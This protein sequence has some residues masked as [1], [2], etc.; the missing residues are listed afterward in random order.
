MELDVL[1]RISEKPV[2]KMTKSDCR[3]A[4]GI[5]MKLADLFSQVCN[6]TG[7]DPESV[8]RYYIEKDEM[9][10]GT[11]LAD[12][13]VCQPLN[14]SAAGFANDAL[15]MA[16]RLSEYL[17][18]KAFLGDAATILSEAGR[19]DEAGAQA[20]KNMQEFP[21]EAWIYIT[22]AEAYKRAGAPDKSSEIFHRA[23]DVV[24]DKTFRSDVYERF[25]EFLKRTGNTAEAGKLEEQFRRENSDDKY[26][27]KPVGKIVFSPHSE[28]KGTSGKG[29]E[30]IGR[31]DPCPC[32]SG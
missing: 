12:A 32:G 1:F 29:K 11:S 14:I 3:A 31:N 28:H 13:L 19:H 24:K 23:L 2:S 4:H 6:A 15:D 17:E 7:A 25:I 27:A 18:P 5:I 22:A 16:R 10:R 9:K 30:K 8:G 20:E 26:T 21:G